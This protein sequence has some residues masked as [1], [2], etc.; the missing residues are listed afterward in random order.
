MSIRLRF[1]TLSN[2]TN[3][4][5]V[6]IYR[7]HLKRNHFHGELPKELRDAKTWDAVFHYCN[8]QWYP[9][10]APDPRA[11]V[12]E[13]FSTLVDVRQC[14]DPPTCERATSSES[15]LSPSQEPNPV[16]RSHEC[17]SQDLGTATHLS[18]QPQE[19]NQQ[20]GHFADISD[21]ASIV[22]PVIFPSKTSD[23]QSLLSSDHMEQFSEAAST[24]SRPAINPTS[25]AGG[26][27]TAMPI[28]LNINESLFSDFFD[29]II[30]PDE[31]VLETLT[32]TV[33]DSHFPHRV[34]LDPNI[35]SSTE[36]PKN[37]DSSSHT[38]SMTSYQKKYSLS[39]A[40]HPRRL[41]GTEGRRRKVFEFDNSKEFEQHFEKWMKDQFTEPPFSWNS[42]GF[43]DPKTGETW[44][45]MD[46]F[47]DD[48][49][50][51][52]VGQREQEAVR[53]LIAREPT[54]E[55]MVGEDTFMN[56]C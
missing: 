28:N 13:L 25:L 51:F 1:Y 12:A 52:L 49:I 21:V 53:Y 4:D 37:S 11:D 56:I 2:V 17:R 55:G 31:S 41:S 14:P 47:T 50:L 44:F 43:S 34:P 6:L 26:Q 36:K 5:V 15:G 16:S 18:P 9:R 27:Y 23:F 54:G 19:E 7:E 24:S 45:N 42:S 10:L 46:D 33:M 40:R 38:P 8:P 30:T 48:L 3:Q 35:G 39:V 32:S 20:L 29:S 22:G